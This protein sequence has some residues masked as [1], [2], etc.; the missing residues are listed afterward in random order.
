[1]SSITIAGG[2]Y[3]E[4]CIWPLWDQL[5][6]S[7]GRAAAALSGHVNA[8]TLR[9]YARPDTAALFQPYADTFGF[10]LHS[11]LAD[12]TVS[13]EY[14]HSLSV[15]VIRP[16]RSKI[17]KNPPFHTSA[18]VVLRFG[19]M[20]GSTIVDANRCIYDPQ[21][22]LHA[23]AFSANGSRANSLAVVAN[24]SEVLAM[25]GG[26]DPIAAAMTLLQNGAEVVVVKSGID[27]AYVVQNSNI[28]HVPAYR[29]NPVWTIG[30]GDIFAAM[31][32]ARWGANGDA[33]VDAALLASRAVA[34]YVESMSLPCPSVSEL[35][36][37]TLSEA[38]LA[39]G[40]VY[41]ASPFFTVGERWVV[42]EARRCL[43]ELG[44]DV[45]SPVHEVGPGP[46]EVVAPADLVGLD[47]SDAVFAILDGKDSGTLFE[48]GYARA[49]DKPVFALAQNV[50]E[51]D[52]KM[53]AGSGCRVFSDFV[54][55]LHHV[56]WRT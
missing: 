4:R 27:G 19:M 40:K 52:L 29:T 13:F 26:T 46:A 9:T 56:A 8:I 16:T 10:T 44:L 24:R 42:D 6:G 21:S 14:I 45:F 2:V 34:A 33:A 25:G 38:T 15:P 43:S 50:S 47:E 49:N 54:T 39:G 32:A 12:Q 55:A 37:A 31:F 5:Y 1:M 18:D 17:R 11:V 20:E 23:E 41:L 22:T 51:E 7:A 36:D 28:T 30:S 48:V 53:V 35:N 3:H